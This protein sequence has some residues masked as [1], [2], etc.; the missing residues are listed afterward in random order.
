M[1]QRDADSYSMMLRNFWLSG[2]IRGNRR[3]SGVVFFLVALAVIAGAVLLRNNKDSIVMLD[4]GYFTGSVPGMGTVHLGIW[5]HEGGA[6]KGSL[7][8]D[9]SGHPVKLEGNRTKEGWFDM[10][11]VCWAAEDWTTNAWLWLRSDKASGGIVG[12]WKSRTNGFLAHFSLRREAATA[13]IRATSNLRVGRYGNSRKFAFVLPQSDCARPGGF[14]SFGEE[15][16]RLALEERNEFMSERF[17]TAVEGVRWPSYGN[18]WEYGATCQIRHLTTNLCSLV[19]HAYPNR[20]GCGD[21]TRYISFSYWSD[22]GTLKR[23]ALRDLFKDGSGWEAFI[24]RYCSDDLKRQ[25]AWD[26]QCESPPPVGAELDVFTWSRSGLQ[27][28][29][30]PYQ[31]GC[32]AEGSYVVNVPFTALARFLRRDGPLRHLQ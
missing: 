16:L 7:A 23:V 25:G 28:Y 24:R 22:A 29:F 27:I 15:L 5:E 32:G 20:G 19:V 2:L 30:N 10:A 31:V 3:I 9:D 1:T 18:Q 17:W 12:V 26:F 6:A 14:G 13:A 8:W 21:P 11:L 4:G